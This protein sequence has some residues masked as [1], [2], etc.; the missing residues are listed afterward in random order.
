MAGSDWTKARWDLVAMDITCPFPDAAK[1][2]KYP[3]LQFVFAIGHLHRGQ[4]H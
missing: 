1:E 4:V 2:L 3:D